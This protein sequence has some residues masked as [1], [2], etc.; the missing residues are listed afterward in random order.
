MRSQILT[1]L[2][3]IIFLI[4]LGITSTAIVSGE[5]VS[6]QPQADQVEFYELHKGELVTWNW[7]SGSY[8][9]DFSINDPENDTYYGS[10]DKLLDEGSFTSP[11][12]GNWSFRWEN[13]NDVNLT[14]D[15]TTILNYTVVIGNEAPSATIETDITSG[16]APLSV[17]FNGI[18]SDTDG[19]IISYLWNIGDGPVLYGQN[20][21][22]EYLNPGSYKVNLTVTDDD[23]AAGY[24]EIDLVV[25]PVNPKLMGSTPVT[26]SVDHPVDLTPTFN[27]DIKM[28]K[29]SVE[30]NITIDPPV[31]ITF[32][33]D[34]LFKEVTMRFPG[35]LDHD[36]PYTLTL[37]QCLSENGGILQSGSSISFTTKVA[38]VP[39][40]NIDPSLNEKE[41]EKGDIVTIN[42]NSTD[43]PA[44]EE[45]TVKVGEATETTY[46]GEDGKWSVSIKVTESGDLP[47]TVT[48]GGIV[49][50]ATLSTKD[51]DEGKDFPWIVLIIV[52]IVVLLLIVA[53]VLFMVIKKK[54][55]G[56]DDTSQYGQQQMMD[57]PTG[58]EQGTLD[59]VGT[60]EVSD[61]P[62][63]PEAEPLKMMDFSEAQ[64]LMEFPDDETVVPEEEIQQPPPPEPVQDPDPQE[65]PAPEV[66][67]QPPVEPAPV[68][69]KAPPPETT[70]PLP[71]PPQPP[72]S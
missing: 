2:L 36:I 14:I 53:I 24:A 48:Y 59:Y 3:V 7:E 63:I 35:G 5:Q 26:G 6:I 67:D 68:E 51:V 40:I 72:I 49:K 37:D 65:T 69:E 30:E 19:E 70:Q 42:G 60:S 27:F 18:G 12:T 38:P 57:D 32:I 39:V 11:I 64:N 45:L 54:K 9:L 66:E 20:V 61:L 28:D 55:S 41:V 47:V 4:T 46:V 34:G 29:N 17:N 8:G 15:F 22:H 50:S 1:S 16:E 25:S 13:Q 10:S 56:K 52:F 31:D 58:I 43:I 44:G 21:S 33:W 62:E 71:P 23:G